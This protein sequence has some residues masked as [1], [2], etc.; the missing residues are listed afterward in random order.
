[1][2]SSQDGANFIKP[3]LATEIFWHASFR[4]A[5][6]YS[7]PTLA[8]QDFYCEICVGRFLV[9]SAIPRSPG[10]RDWAPRNRR[11]QAGHLLVRP[12][13]WATNSS[14]SGSPCGSTRHF[15]GGLSSMGFVYCDV[16]EGH[17]ARVLN[18]I[19]RRQLHVSPSRRFRSRY[20]NLKR[21]AIRS[22]LSGEP[23]IVA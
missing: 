4:Y 12:S 20:G 22:A 23:A 19:A 7:L 17:E 13:I 8:C 9:R 16:R 2:Q 1:M 15:H 3:L 6:Y 14:S 10:R 11:Y 5:R 18:E 21:S